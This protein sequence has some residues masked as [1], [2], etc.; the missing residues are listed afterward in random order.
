MSKQCRRRSDAA[1][2]ASDQGLLSLPLIQQVKDIRRSKM[3]LLHFYGSSVIKNFRCPD[4]LVNIVL[5]V[6]GSAKGMSGQMLSWKKM[7]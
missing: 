3:E 5:S 4:F 6:K 7:D 2:A 1:N